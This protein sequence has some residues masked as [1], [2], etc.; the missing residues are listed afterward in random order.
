MKT[1]RPCDSVPPVRFM[2]DLTNDSSSNGVP[3]LLSPVG[4]KLSGG[5][6]V[7]D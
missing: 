6:P 7:P 2:Y 1:L 5:C 4:F 3:P